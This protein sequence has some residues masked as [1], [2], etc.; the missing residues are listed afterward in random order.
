VYSAETRGSS[1]ISLRASLAPPSRVS[2]CCAVDARFPMTGDPRPPKPW[3]HST[4][5]PPWFSSRAQGGSAR[6]AT[7]KRDTRKTTAD[8][9]PL[10]S[11]LPRSRAHGGREAAE[12]TSHAAFSRGPERG[13]PACMMLHLYPA[14][15]H[16]AC[17]VPAQKPSDGLL[18]AVKGRSMQDRGYELPRTLA[19]MRSTSA[20]PLVRASSRSLLF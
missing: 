13:K 20:E 6:R 1:T 17:R 18:A 12:S 14:P 5:A 9:A 4:R 15:Q 11:T 19:K 3:P 7:Q 16:A 8:T 10:P 2:C